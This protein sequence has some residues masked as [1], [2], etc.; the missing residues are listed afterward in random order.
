MNAG[1]VRFDGPPQPNLTM[2]ISCR[3]RRIRDGTTPGFLL[4]GNLLLH[5]H[6]YGHLSSACRMVGTGWAGL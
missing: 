5:H 6:L 2:V 3:C 4:E 1:S